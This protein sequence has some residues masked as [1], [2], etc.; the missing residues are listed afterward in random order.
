MSRSYDVKF[1]KIKRNASSK[2]PSYV[3]RWTVDGKECSKTFGGSEHAENFLSD[4]RQAAR[5]G[6]WFDTDTGLPESM[7]KAKNARTWLEFARAYLNVQWPHHAAKTRANTVE[8]LVVVTLAL[9]AAR[10]S[11]PDTTSLRKALRNHVFVPD[12][13][14]PKQRD[15]QTNAALRWLDDA[16]V[17]M[18]SLNETRHARA[19]LEALA[20]LLDGRAAAP[21]TF[22][23]RRAVFHHALEYAVELGELDVN[24]LDRVKV[25]PAK[26]SN[27]VDRRVVVNPSQARELMIA[28]TY[29]GRTRGPMLAAMFACMYFAGLR[30]AEA[31]GLRKQDCFLPEKGW[32]RITLIRTRPQSNTRYTDSGRSFDERGLKHRQGDD[33]RVVPIPPELVAILRAHI[34]TFG[35][36]PD[37]RLF[38]TRG[39]GTFSGTSYAK[40]W[41]AGRC[42]ALTPDR[43]ASPLAGRPYDLRHAAVSLWLNAGVHAPEVAERAGHSV[44]VLLR[45]YAKCID[46]QQDIANQRIEKALEP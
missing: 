29:F 37:D 21:K 3:V 33:D 7:F 19:A 39:G 10:Q 45:T 28:V 13:R 32:G 6:E 8:A 25:K 23:R 38:F 43:V 20:V 34:D 31:Q 2:K 1:W 18:P 16:S 40:V 44:D 15:A 41:R 22:A 24:P 46:G 30:P 42:L 26:S 14:Q 12:D 5:R 27:V 35:T 11:R 36:A 17:P 4:L 9:T